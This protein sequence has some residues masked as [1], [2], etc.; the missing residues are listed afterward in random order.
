MN[1][2]FFF[3]NLSSISKFLLQ[4]KLCNVYA[5]RKQPV[6]KRSQHQRF[7]FSKNR[8]KLAKSSAQCPFQF[9]SVPTQTMFRNFCT[10][11]FCTRNESSKT[12]MT[13]Q[14][15]TRILFINFNKE[16]STTLISLGLVNYT[17]WYKKREKHTHVRA[18]EVICGK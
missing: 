4:K 7:Y 10:P 15:T 6:Y 16:S 14:N 9:S 13:D 11:T 1:T 3:Q 17:V 8:E 12:S 18:I 5:V 2:Y